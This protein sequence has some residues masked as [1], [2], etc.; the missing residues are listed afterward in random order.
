MSKP[1]R[2]I[3]V[4]ISPDGTMVGVAEGVPGPDCLDE[5]PRIEE[6]CGGVVVD[7]R[8]TPEYHQVR[9]DADEFDVDVAKDQ[10]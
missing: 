10:L 2:R 3:R 5:S 7:S 8:L 9:E 1:T 4:T 6:L